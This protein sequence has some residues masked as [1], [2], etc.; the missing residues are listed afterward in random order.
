MGVQWD[1][2]DEDGQ[3]RNPSARKAGAVVRS[4]LA[5]ALPEHVRDACSELARQLGDAPG[6]D[7][8][9]WTRAEGYHLTLRFLGNVAVERL[10]EIAKRTEEELAAF[11]PFALRLTH[12]F[13]FPTPKRPRVIAV[14]TDPTQ[15]LEALAQRIE[16]A[17]EAAGLAPE[18][19][20]FR[21]HLTLGRVR[22]RRH[23]T[24]DRAVVPGAPEFRVAEVVLFRSDLARDGARYTPLETIVLGGRAV[25]G[26]GGRTN[27]PG[28][29]G[30]TP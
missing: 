4:F 23:P 20:A 22:S 26:E 13:G 7:G 14:G 29:P 24:L 5:V 15:P 17:V 18:T 19:R 11:A 30:T 8:V 6:G 27:H 12:A 9:R 1:R 16:A 25:R 21:P 2:S 28:H 3:L 10:P